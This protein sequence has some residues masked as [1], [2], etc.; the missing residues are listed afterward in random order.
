M[1]KY[2]NVKTSG[3][4]SKREHRRALELRLLMQ[5]GEITELREQT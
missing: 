4:D 3:Y 5:S 1:N 2:R